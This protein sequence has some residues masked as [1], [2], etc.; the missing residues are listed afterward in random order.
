[1]SLVKIKSKETMLELYRPFFKVAILILI[2]LGT[3]QIFEVTK[4]KFGFNALNSI[5]M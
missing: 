2:F 4:L 1:M 3:L 5:I